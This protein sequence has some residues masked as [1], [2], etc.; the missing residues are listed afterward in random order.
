M[1]WKF[2]FLLC[3]WTF[4]E[5]LC[6]VMEQDVA[7]PRLK[8]G[9][10][11]PN[12]TDFEGPI[13]SGCPK[14]IHVVIE[15]CDET[16]EAEVT[17]AVPTAVDLVSEATLFEHNFSPGDSFPINE[18]GHLV[19]YDFI[20]AAGNIESCEFRVIVTR[21]RGKKCR[22]DCIVGE[23]RRIP[24]R[25]SFVTSDC[26]QRCTCN[27]GTLVCEPYGCGEKQMCRRKRRKPRNCYCK[28]GYLKDKSGECYKKCPDGFT[29]FETSCYKFH[30]EEKNFRQAK[31]ICKKQK[32]YLVTI[33]SQEENDFVYRFIEPSKGVWLG[34]K[35]HSD[36]AF[37]VRTDSLKYTF[38][39]ELTSDNHRIEFFLLADDEARLLLSSKPTNK[40]NMY[41]LIFTPSDVSLRLCKKCKYVA[42]SPLPFNMTSSGASIFITFGGGYISVGQSGKAPFFTWVHRARL[43]FQIAY[44]GI[45][46]Q[47]PAMW[48]FFDRY[49][50]VR[51]EPWVYENWSSKEPNSYNERR[52]CS[53]MKGDCGGSWSDTCCS[54]KKS[55]VCEKK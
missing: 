37:S 38:V 12:N 10:V 18:E 19:F 50:W 29:A 44:V 17:W 26:S 21:G 22:P 7:H 16:T 2:L 52:G 40:G 31:K 9:E 48:H 43:T 6:S 32:S 36:W 24:S 5:S 55:F 33:S 11:D 28:R 42:T 13:I 20:D 34:A 14:N 35:S 1:Y 27:A 53:V 3:L 15:K 30:P 4:Q 54:F 25:K 8:R 46:S 49:T 39:K 47:N 45:A 51:R 23:D 41:E